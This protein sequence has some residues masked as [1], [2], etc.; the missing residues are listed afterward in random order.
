MEAY[1]NYTTREMLSLRYI[2]SPFARTW[3]SILSRTDSLGTSDGD[4]LVMF[5]FL[6]VKGKRHYE[7]K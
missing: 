7:E 2:K 4:A 6:G 3:N 5:R 1:S